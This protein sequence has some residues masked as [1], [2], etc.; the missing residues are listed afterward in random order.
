MTTTDES[1]NSVENN[2]D[3]LDQVAL[4]VYREEDG[5]SPMLLCHWANVTPGFL[6]SYCVKLVDDGQRQHID[7]EDCLVY[8]VASSVSAKAFRLMVDNIDKVPTVSPSPSSQRVDIS[9]LDLFE[10]CIVLWSHVCKIDHWVFVA[11]HIRDLHWKDDFR[12]WP[13][14]RLTQWLFIALVFDWPNIF[15]MASSS[16]IVDFSEL[17][18]ELNSAH[19]LPREVISEYTSKHALLRPASRARICVLRLTFR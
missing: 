8:M 16:L 17:D 19:Y 5:N 6:R 1:T 3:L 11:E 2:T 14:G 15:D 4:R 7:D 9:F 13:A 12:Q 10:L 18:A